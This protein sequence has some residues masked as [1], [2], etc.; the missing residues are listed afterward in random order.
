MGFVLSSF[1]VIR[2]SMGAAQFLDLGVVPN[3]LMP[4]ILICHGL[5]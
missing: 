5:A 4:T 3:T 1:P 2:R